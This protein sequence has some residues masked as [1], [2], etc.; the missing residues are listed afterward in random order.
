M[1][2]LAM[3]AAANGGY[4]TRAELSAF[5]FGA[6]E[7]M[8]LVDSSRGIRNP[9][10]LSA[11][12]TVMSSADGPYADTELEDGLFRY[13]YRVGSSGGD[14]AKLRRAYELQVPI[15]LLR[16]I[17][18]GVF[19]PIFPVFV[20][21]DD[22]DHR[23]FV[24]ALDES[25]RFLAH[26]LAPT[27]NERRY[28][29]RVVQQ[30]LHQPEF[31]GR[32]VR[33]YETRCAIC[34]LRHGE[35]L[36]A[37]HIIGDGQA[38]GQPVVRNGVCLCKIHH[39]AYDRNLLGITPDYVVKINAQLLAEVDGPMLK[40]GLQDMHGSLLVLPAREQ[41]QPDPER[42]ALRFGQFTGG[43]DQA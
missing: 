5:R 15:I 27:E 38:L 6:G 19:V 18:P 32:V 25:L 16:K 43:L 17:E 34:S 20:I 42:L 41:D 36:D 39:A 31:R 7:T 24:L 8:R 1:T 29:E 28:A 33:A 40:H 9:R 11:T 21:A 12:L 13:D 30:R 14:N 4:V 37:A 3:R 22:L 2:T 23:Q 26:P 10:E 35:L